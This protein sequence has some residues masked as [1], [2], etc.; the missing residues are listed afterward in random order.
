MFLMCMNKFGEFANCIN[1]L[2]SHVCFRIEMQSARHAKCA[3]Y[4]FPS[5]TIPLFGWVKVYAD[6]FVQTM[7]TSHSI[8]AINNTMRSLLVGS[9]SAMYLCIARYR[10]TFNCDM[11]IIE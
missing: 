10:L 7:T 11:Y 5:R 8:Q 4:I 2:I 3:L 9:F 1:F 6:Y